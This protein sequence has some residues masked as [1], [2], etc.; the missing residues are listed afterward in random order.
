[1]EYWILLVIL[2][3]G[4]CAKSTEP[5]GVIV[6]ET[7]SLPANGALTHTVWTNSTGH[8]VYIHRGELHMISQDGDQEFAA[9]SFRISDNEPFIVQGIY[10]T[11]ETP[12]SYLR[13]FLPDCVSIKPGDG[14]YLNCTYYSFGAQLTVQGAAYLI[15][16]YSLD[17]P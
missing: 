1:M 17:A 3:S 11:E 13:D 14:I 2:C 9:H 10:C 4:V 5:V 7:G 8:T 15:I 6:C 16:W 12:H